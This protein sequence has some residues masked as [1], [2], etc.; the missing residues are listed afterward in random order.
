VRI[1]TDGTPEPNPTD[2]PTGGSGNVDIESFDVQS[3]QILRG[4]STIE[5]TLR[6]TPGGTASVQVPGVVKDLVLRESTRGVYTGSYVV[7]M[8]TRTPVTVSRAT[9]IARLRVGQSERLIQ[10]SG[11]LQVDNQPP[12]V[13]STTPEANGRVNSLRPNI[14]AVFDDQGGTGVDSN[15]VRLSVDGRDVSSEA[16]ITASLLAYRPDR[17]LGAGKHDVSIEVR[18]RAG[19]LATKAWSFT[20]VDRASVI[21][22][23]T[24][25][26]PSVIQAGDE[27]TF[28]LTGEADATVTMQ[29]GEIRTLTMDEVS[30]GR[31]TA[32]YVVRRTDRL[33]GVVVTA[34]MKT[35]SGETFSTDL[36]LGSTVGGNTSLTAPTITS[37]QNNATVGRTAVFKGKAD[38]N[39]KVRVKIDF[40]QRVFGAIPMSGTIAE[41]EVDAD[42][43][44][45]WE[46]REIDL[47]TGLGRDNI[48]YTISVVSIGQDDK[49]SDV[50]KITL[51]R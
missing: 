7:P 26:A 24:H 29:L 20:I 23:F 39:A 38:P 16:T 37:H 22:A 51:K 30:A 28:T 40:T 48:T 5:F 19:N 31:Y 14:T 47:D 12:L 6:G 15:V 27:I 43:K 46:T 13:T 34:K 8:G 1:G 10:A 44:G 21:T 35:K 41:V 33:D 18:D 49:T 11:T 25:N 17:N 3:D 32:S 42:S 4:G 45:L 2:P 50:T 9:A 36:T